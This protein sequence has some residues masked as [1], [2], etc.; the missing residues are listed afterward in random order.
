M[1]ISSKDTTPIRIGQHVQIY[2]KSHARRHFEQYFGP[3]I[4]IDDES[5]LKM[6]ARVLQCIFHMLPDVYVSLREE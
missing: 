1:S 5:R 2:I 4:C 6:A 3:L